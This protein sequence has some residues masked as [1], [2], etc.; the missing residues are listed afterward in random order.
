[1]QC[2]SLPPRNFL[3]SLSISVSK[4]KEDNTREIHG[5]QTEK[6]RAGDAQ[7]QLKIKDITSRQRGRPTSTNL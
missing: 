7:Q 5:T 3:I 4:R 2:L 1:M 6:D